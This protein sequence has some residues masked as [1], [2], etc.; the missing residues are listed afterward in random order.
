MINWE[1]RQEVNNPVVNPTAGGN[2]QHCSSR[3][4][5]CESRK[6]QR[7]KRQEKACKLILWEKYLCNLSYVSFTSNADE[8]P[9][10]DLQRWELSPYPETDQSTVQRFT[11]VFTS[12]ELPSRP[13]VPFI[14]WKVLSLHQDED[15][16]VSCESEASLGL[17]LF[18]GSMSL[19]VRETHIS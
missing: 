1:W 15:K 8:R 11:P 9:L 18:S 17:T 14:F 19:L 10:Q 3:R 5:L 13:T 12:A 16:H 4:G 2:M 7:E 6:Y